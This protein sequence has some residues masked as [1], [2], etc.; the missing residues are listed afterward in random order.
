MGKSVMKLRFID[1]WLIGENENWFT[2]MSGQ[3]LHLKWLSG[4][5]AHFERGEPM[6]YK[7]RIDFASSEDGVFYQDQIDFYND[8][9]WER[10][11]IYDDMCVFRSD[12]SGGLR[13]PYNT[14]R[15]S[16]RLRSRR[17]IYRRRIR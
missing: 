4:S 17:F 12:A 14:S 10:V 6:K 7:Y 11:D 5:F 15:R 8:N 9:G 16:R 1:Q 13:Q 3:G 2:H